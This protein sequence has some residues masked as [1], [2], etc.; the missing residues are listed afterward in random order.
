MTLFLRHLFVLCA[1]LSNLIQ[2][3]ISSVTYV[4]LHTF[5]INSPWLLAIVECI[6]T[7]I[8]LGIGITKHFLSNLFKIAKALSWLGLELPL[9]KAM[10]WN[11]VFTTTFHLLCIQKDIHNALELRQSMGTV[12]LYTASAFDLLW[13]YGLLYKMSSFSMNLELIALILLI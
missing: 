8:N 5:H 11:L 7:N 1:Q 2:F 3:G 4:A 13:H 10:Y 6:S 12:F 9:S